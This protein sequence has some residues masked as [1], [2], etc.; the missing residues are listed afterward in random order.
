M[1]KF[2]TIVK[3]ILLFNKKRE[4]VKKNSNDLELS[5]HQMSLKKLTLMMKI[6]K[7]IEINIED[8]V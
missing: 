2:S 5:D 7:N 3:W 4:K 1:D 6:N 8:C